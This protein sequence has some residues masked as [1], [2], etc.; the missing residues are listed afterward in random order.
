[1]SPEMRKAALHGML[2][3]A[4][5][6]TRSLVKEYEN[7][8]EVGREIESNRRSAK[9]IVRKVA[10]E[11]LTEL[12][13]KDHIGKLRK[14]T[15]RLDVFRH[16]VTEA[17]SQDDF[18]ILFAQIDAELEN[19]SDHFSNVVP[20]LHDKLTEAMQRQVELN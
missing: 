4:Y 18:D 17:E 19:A 8:Q 7:I 16:A 1:M 2:T 9:P 14:L 15:E 5:N 13:E 10:L 11:I 6:R 20:L 12:D 3:L